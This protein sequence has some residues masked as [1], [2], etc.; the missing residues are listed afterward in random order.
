MLKFVLVL[1]VIV[2][3]VV[4][5]CQEAAAFKV[6]SIHKGVNFEVKDWK[7]KKLVNYKNPYP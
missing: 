2:A 1:S 5:P 7:R 3:L 4:M 6:I